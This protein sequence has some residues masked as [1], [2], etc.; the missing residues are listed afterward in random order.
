MRQ[1]WISLFV[2]GLL[3]ACSLVTLA[4][5]Q[6]QFKV[7]DKVEVRNMSSVWVPATV[8]RVS[9]WGEYGDGYAYRIH[10]DDPNAANPEWNALSDRIRAV[11]QPPRDVP[12]DK[13]P[14]G[15]DRPPVNGGPL[16]AGD[17]ADVFYDAKLYGGVRG[18]DRGTIIEVGNGRYKIH[19]TGCKPYWD[20]WVDRE[21]VRPSATI[22]VG[23]PE[24]SFLV[25]KWSMTTV[26]IS[27]GSISWGKSND[28]QINGDGTYTWYQTG[29][30]PPVKGRW[31]TDAKLEG[32]KE[33]TAKIDGI[34]VKDAA[35]HEW[36]LYRRI[37]NPG[38][39]DK[40]TIHQM[41][42]GMTAIGTRAR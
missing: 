28:I 23:A 6:P 39:A 10:I 27:N 15:N 17:L 35:G 26:G 9:A 34:L 33:G 7:G 4:Q 2:S 24:I 8:L 29:G 25:G 11:P 31:I 13:P 37:V 18:K 1:Y 40:V 42:E 41:C 14:G 12:I 22:S 20:E 36:K 30:K 21:Q 5:N 16:K 32:A 19:Y 3:L 38:E